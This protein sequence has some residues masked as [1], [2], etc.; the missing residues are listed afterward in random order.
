MNKLK[1]L[2]PR[3]VLAST[4]ES[5]QQGSKTGNC[6]KITEDRLNKTPEILL[7]VLIPKNWVPRSGVFHSVVECLTNI[8][9]FCV[10]TPARTEREQ[11]TE[12]W[13]GP[14]AQMKTWLLTTLPHVHHHLRVLLLLLCV[15]CLCKRG[16]P[17][18]QQKPLAESPYRSTCKVQVA[19]GVRTGCYQ[20]EASGNLRF[21]LVILHPRASNAKWYIFGLRLKRI[22]FCWSLGAF[23]LTKT[24]FNSIIWSKIIPNASH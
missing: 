2:L 18:S 24:I 17:Q 23:S 11:S 12:L 1:T 16:E 20:L 13:L 10:Q 21:F 22:A 14:Y 3:K 8:R 19:C 15:R 6:Y 4:T 5:P 9:K 7:L